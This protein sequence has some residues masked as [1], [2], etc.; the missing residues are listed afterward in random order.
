MTPRSRGAALADT[1]NPPRGHS[2]V[3][4]WRLEARN[5]AGGGATFSFTL[6]VD[7]AGP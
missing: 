5:N 6:P 1:E 2:V 4:R 3:T 7:G